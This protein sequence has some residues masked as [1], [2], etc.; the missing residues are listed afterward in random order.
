MREHILQ[1]IAQQ[2]NC[3]RRM[4]IA[5]FPAYSRGTIYRYI[6]QLLDAGEI[7]ETPHG[8]LS[9]NSPDYKVPEWPLHP[10][11]RD[12]THQ[13]EQLPMLAEFILA[14]DRFQEMIEPLIEDYSQELALLLINLQ[15][16]FASRQGAELS[17]HYPH[18]MPANKEQLAITVAK[19]GRSLEAFSL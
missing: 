17:E 8:T 1:F 7:F 3:T 2:D 12:A 5:N 16:M 15:I 13:P 14:P 4:I 10:I 9:T 19:I 6:N 18:I 11:L